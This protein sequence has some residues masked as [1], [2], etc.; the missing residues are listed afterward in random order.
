MPILGGDKKKMSEV[1]LAKSLIL[2][3]SP[4]NSLPKNIRVEE[5]T[6]VQIPQDEDVLK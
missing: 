5:D 3:D 4:A 1:D 2:K 6:S